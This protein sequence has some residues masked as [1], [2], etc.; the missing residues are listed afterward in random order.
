MQPTRLFRRAAGL[1]VVAVVVAA[2]AAAAHPFVHDGATIPAGSLT[3]MTLAMGHG[4]GDELEGGGQPTLEVAMEVPDEVSYIKPLD[5]DGYEAGVET[6][7]DGRVEVVSWVATDG[8]VATPAVP[9]EIVVDGAEGDELFL[10]VFQ[11]CEAFQYRWVGTPDEPA[12][13]P[14]VPITLAAP[15]PDSPPPPAE[16]PPPTTAEEPVPDDETDGE[17]ASREVPPTG[18]ASPPTVEPSSPAEEASAAVDEQSASFPWV[19]VVIG[20]VVLGATIA[21]LVAWRRSVSRRT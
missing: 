6:A 8:G 5:V 1:A 2:T 17:D 4:C 21:L 3:T 15:D 9:M 7:T 20:L 11:G 16:P 10:K 14:A 19:P 18:E 12:D 13:D